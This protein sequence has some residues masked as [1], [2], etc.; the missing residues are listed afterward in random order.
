MTALRGTFPTLV[1]YAAR[2]PLPIF[3][4]FHRAKHNL[5]RYAEESL[6][7]HENL[8][9]SDSTSVQKSLFTGIFKAQSEEKLTFS[10]VRSNAQG[11]IIAGSDTT[12]NTLTYLIWAVC[13]NP[14]IKKKLVA[15]LRTLPDKYEHSHLRNLPYLHQVVQE[16]LRLYSAVPLML[17]R[18]VPPEGASLCGYSLEPGTTVATQA[19]TMHRDP[20]VF[21]DPERFD[22]ERWAEPSKAMNDAFMAFGRGSRGKFL[23]TFS[24]ERPRLV[25]RLI[26]YS[27][28]WLTSC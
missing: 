7:M 17:P 8:V 2:L 15:E 20:A 24:R 12:S 25:E 21:P 13:K 11:Y 19:Y 14:D 23:H 10:E 5:R 1:S 18:I 26:K 27:V 4:R 16:V 22:P 28:H 9:L 3:D 6:R